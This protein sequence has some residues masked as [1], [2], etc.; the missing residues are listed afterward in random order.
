M[1]GGSLDY[2]YSKLEMDVGGKMHDPEMEDLLQDFIK[3]LH[4]LEWWLSSDI[5]REAYM[6]TLNNFKKKWLRGNP[7]DHLKPLIEKRIEQTRQELFDMLGE[8]EGSKS[9]R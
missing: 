9:G 3:V 8:S 4:D 1:S 7:V 6:K 5:G 2:A